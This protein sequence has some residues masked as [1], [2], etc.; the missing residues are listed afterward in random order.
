MT[1][2]EYLASTAEAYQAYLKEQTEYSRRYDRGH[3][4]ALLERLRETHKAACR[5]YD[6]VTQTAGLHRENTTAAERRLDEREV[7]RAAL[8]RD[9][10]EIILRGFWR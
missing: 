1:D 10:L 7:E 8:I 4:Q 3:L 6:R 9:Q 2:E 5:H